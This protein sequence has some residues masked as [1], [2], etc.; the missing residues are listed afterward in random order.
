MRLMPIMQ[1]P[2]MAYEFFGTRMVK[3]VLLIVR[4]FG[5]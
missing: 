2:P 1:L 3:N 5:G 4:L